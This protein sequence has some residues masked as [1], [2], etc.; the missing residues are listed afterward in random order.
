[1]NKSFSAV[2][3]SFSKKKVCYP[4][5]SVKCCMADFFFEDSLFGKAVLKHYSR[6][7]FENFTCQ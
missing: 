7:L 6:V 3:M 4:T 5:L 1:M 2:Q